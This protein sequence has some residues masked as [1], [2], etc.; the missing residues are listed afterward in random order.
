MSY[1]RGLTTA[2]PWGPVTRTDPGDE[3]LARSGGVTPSTPIF[4]PPRSTM[5]AR[6]IL[7]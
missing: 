1:V 6:A 3:M 7:G 5:V 2:D 4:W